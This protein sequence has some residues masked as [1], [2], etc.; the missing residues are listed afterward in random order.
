[1]EAKEIFKKHE[2]LLAKMNKYI[3]GSYTNGNHVTTICDD[4]TRIRETLNEADT[5]FTFDSAENFDCKIT[6]YCDGGC[7]YCHEGSS[8]KGKHCD[9]DLAIFDTLHPFQEI[10]LGG[11]NIFSHPQLEELLKKIKEQNAIANITVNQKHLK[12]N[13]D[14]IK[15]F[16][17]NKLI[18][19]IGISLTDSSD[20]EDKSIIESFG[21]N[22][23]IHVINGIFTEKDLDFIKD[24]KVLILGYKDNIRKGKKFYDAN[25]LEIEKNKQWLKDNLEKI[26][27]SVKSISF[28]NLALLQLDVKNTLNIDDDY[29]NIVY[30]GREATSTFYVDAVTRTIGKTSTCPMEERAKLKK[31]TTVDKAFKMAKDTTWQPK[32]YDF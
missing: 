4:G 23:V 30:Q 3:L 14:L 19:G 32:D 15:L 28:D 2:N 6:N 17:D 25:T 24:K 10:A 31:F 29:W 22:C 13:K 26:K 20:D 27:E 7:A 9:I 21:N 1:M 18:N 5:D 8:I 11:G 12:K 16:I